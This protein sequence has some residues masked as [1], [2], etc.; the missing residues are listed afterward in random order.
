[1]CEKL[2]VTVSPSL[3]RESGVYVFHVVIPETA[4]AGESRT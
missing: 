4:S 2:A 3:Q 1:M